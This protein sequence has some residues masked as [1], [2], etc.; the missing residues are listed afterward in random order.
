MQENPARSGQ[1]RLA[2]SEVAASAKSE[3]GKQMPSL[4]RCARHGNGLGDASSRGGAWGSLGRNSSKGKG[5]GRKSVWQKPRVLVANC[6]LSRV[7][8]RLH[9]G[10]Q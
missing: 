1:V 2:P 4:M 3:S 9:T 10:L 8:A 6:G 5:L 7:G